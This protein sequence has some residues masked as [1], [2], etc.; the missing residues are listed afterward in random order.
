MIKSI[1]KS[2]FFFPMLILAAA[3]AVFSVNVLRY[4]KFPEID[5]IEPAVAYPGENITITGT[6]F[7]NSRDGAEVRIAGERPL[8]NY[9]EMWTDTEIVVKVPADVGSGMVTVKTRRGKSNGVLFSNREHIPVILTGPQKP[10]YPYMEKVEPENG[11]VGSLV[12]ISGLNFGHERGDAAVFFTAAGVGENEMIKCSEIDYDYESW[13]E[14]EV[15]VYIPD[16]AASGNIRIQTDRGMSNALYYEITGNTGTKKFSDK[17]GF[18]VE[19]GIDISG[20]ESSDQNGLDLWVPAVKQGLEQRSVEIVTE[21]QPLWKDYFGL[22][23]YHFNDLASGETYKVSVKTWL[24]RYEVETLI[25]SSRVRNW[26]NEERKLFKEYTAAESLIPSDSDVI[27]S[28]V[29]RAAGNER[30]PY[31]RASLIY[32]YILKNLEFKTKPASS[33]VL[34]NIEN[35]EGDSYTCSIMFTAMCRA[36]G[37]PARPLAGVLV[38]DNKQAAN[39]FW[40]EFYIK[41]FGWVPV[42]PALGDGARFGNFPIDEEIDPMEYYFGSIDSHHIC[43]TRGVVPVKKID[44]AGSVSGRISRYSLQ[45]I[46]E[47][48]IGI[49]GYSSYWRAV[50]IVDWW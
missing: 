16:G 11:S 17:M 39:H 35:G 19:Y 27:T 50:R 33:S 43:L 13:D 38:Y 28:A 20:V 23:R 45:T 41:E 18:Q 3:V 46:Y 24:E 1:I 42:D 12:T 21:P 10:G 25:T 30:N 36:A 40:A 47:E 6:N 48:S 8:S 15:K 26:Y 44:P 49:I 37:I 22:M 9:Y 32:N 31:R 2:R 5:N 14:Q 34:Q 4:Y 29:R 7:G